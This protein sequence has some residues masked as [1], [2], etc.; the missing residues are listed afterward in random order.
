MFK[1]SAFPVAIASS[2][3]L[4]PISAHAQA[5]GLALIS[6]LFNIFVGLM[7]VAA[8]LL[9]FGGLIGW[10]LR[11]G[12]Y[13]SYRDE[14]IRVLQWSVAILF[15]LVVMLGAIRFVQTYQAAAAFMMGIV[16]FIG[17]VWAVVT[18]ATSAPKKDDKKDGN[19]NH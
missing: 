10:Y 14:M 13:P 2:T 3:I 4:L 18:L 12:P 5:S 15:V 1:N 7:L 9:F 16:I 6:G 11:R 8:V 17:A 19:N